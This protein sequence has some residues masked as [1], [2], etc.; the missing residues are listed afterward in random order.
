MLNVGVDAGVGSS[1]GSGKDGVDTGVAG[2][3]ADVHIKS[4]GGNVPIADN[5]QEL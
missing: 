1:V 4:T 3:D 2:D 5:R